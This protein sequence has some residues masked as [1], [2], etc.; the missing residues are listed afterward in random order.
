TAETISVMLKEADQQ[1]QSK[2]IDGLW[3]L[4]PGAEP[5][6]SS[7]EDVK[8]YT[9]CDDLEAARGDL[10]SARAALRERKG[11]VFMAYKHALHLAGLSLGEGES[12]TEIVNA[13]AANIRVN[14][15]NFELAR[16]NK[17][18]I[19]LITAWAEKHK[20]SPAS[21]DDPELLKILNR[22]VKIS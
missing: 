22:K 8:S 9:E 1:L 4:P 19:E 2:K 6:N 7:L 12:I 14:D 11:A 15:P 10:E 5:L 17:K 20:D 18:D 13:A 21:P 3:D 16:P